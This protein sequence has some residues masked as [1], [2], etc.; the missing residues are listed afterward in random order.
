M[1]RVANT[2]LSINGSSS[3]SAGHKTLTAENSSVLPLVSKL[4]RTMANNNIAYCH[5]KSNNALDRSA[6]GDNDLDLLVSPADKARLTAILFS[7][8]FKEARAPKEKYMPDVF[9]YFGFDKTG[10]K[11]VHAHV[12][13]KL[14]LGHDMSKN[15]R[16]PIEEQYLR[17]A[18]QG[19]L[20]KV[21]APEYEYIVLVVRMVLK[22]LTW[23]AIVGREGSLNKSER[24]EL[25]YLQERIDTARVYAILTQDLPYLPAELFDDCVNGLRPGTSVW[26]RAAIGR[27]L[28]SSLQANA[29]RALPVDVTLKVSRRVSAAVRHRIFKKS[30]KYRLERA[31]AM[32]AIV[33]GDGAGKSTAVD[34]LHAWLAKH[35][36]VTRIHMGKPS[37]SWTTKTVRGLLKLGQIAGLYPVES[38]E[39]ETI[40][41]Q[42]FISPGYPWLIREALRARDRRLSYRKAQR[43]VADG[44]IVILDRFPLPQIEIMDGP[45]SDRFVTQL[46]QGPQADQRLAPRHASRFTKALIRLEERFYQDI[47]APTLLFVLRVDPEI[48]VQRKTDEEPATVRKRSTAIW[49][50]DWKNTGAQVIDAGKSKGDVLAELKAAIWTGL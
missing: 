11:L 41:Q 9:D 6:G 14:V 3:Q 27:Q 17:S 49:K 1:H 25:A 16:L 4:C 44:G 39:E 38:T 29:R 43:F 7:L 50:L 32:I 12:H 24:K 48:A 2:Q 15:Y 47:V 37:W 20:F 28:V 35:F 45:Q 46:E 22:H 34:A 18:V 42:S 19:E 10:D 31:G 30:S 40:T 23:D 13:Y 26:R 33:G 21:P 36:T 8:G 5:W